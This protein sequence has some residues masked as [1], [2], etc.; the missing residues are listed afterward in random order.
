[1]QRRNRVLV[2]VLLLVVGMLASVG[3]SAAARICLE[4]EF[5]GEY[6]L[7]ANGTVLT[8]FLSFGDEVQAIAVGSRARDREFTVYGLNFSAVCPQVGPISLTI[9]LDR[10]GE[11]FATGVAFDCSGDST[12][13]C[14][15][16][17]EGGEPL[18]DG[19]A[20]AIRTCR[21]SEPRESRGRHP[22][23]AP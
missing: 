8:G 13:V 12:S 18:C 16:V 5:G 10:F 22:L 7:D 1:M 6:N 2:P 21:R 19:P 20:I 4:D 14:D 11:G 3:T 23:L 15:D 9:F 17:F